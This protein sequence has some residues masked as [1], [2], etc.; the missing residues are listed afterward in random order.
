MYCNFNEIVD[1]AKKIG[2]CK[3]AVL[4]PD[5]PDIMRAMADGFKQKLIEPVLV[6]NLAR[7]KDVAHHVKLSLDN[8]GLIHQE[9]PQSAADL[10]LNMVKEGQVAFVVTV[11]SE[12]ESKE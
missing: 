12:E 8:M 4:F 1:R 9:D 10:C 5:S 3:V 2:P 11:P 7:I 6:G